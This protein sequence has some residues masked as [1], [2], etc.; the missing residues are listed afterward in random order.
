MSRISYWF[1]MFPTRAMV[2][3]VL[4]FFSIALIPLVFKTPDAYS[5]AN[6]RWSAVEIAKSEDRI[7]EKQIDVEHKFE[8][9]T[10]R[11]FTGDFDQRGQSQTDITGVAAGSTDIAKSLAIEFPTAAYEPQK[12]AGAIKRHPLRRAKV[13]DNQLRKSLQA[14]AEANTNYYKPIEL[15]PPNFTTSAY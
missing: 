7:F 6:V 15:P 5:N 3:A 8:V 10:R 11:Q 4:I 9:T 13:A 2:F 12:V 1:G 14:N